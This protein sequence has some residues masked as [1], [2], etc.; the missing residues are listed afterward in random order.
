MTNSDDLVERL[1]NHEEQQQ[2]AGHY[3]WETP[4][5]CKEAADY[6][7]ELE[8]AVEWQRGGAER[9]EA[10]NARLREALRPFACTLEPYFGYTEYALFGVWEDVN[11]AAGR[12]LNILRKQNFDDARAAIAQ[13]DA[14]PD[15]RLD[16]PYERGERRASIMPDEPITRDDLAEAYRAGLEAAAD[17]MWSLRDVEKEHHDR[18]YARGHNAACLGSSRAIRALPVPPEFGGE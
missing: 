3:W 7:E 9:A 16:T 10:E 18:G 1:R 5:V 15:K 2:V 13:I 17:Y 11:G 12:K 6:I 4:E 14:E 8:A